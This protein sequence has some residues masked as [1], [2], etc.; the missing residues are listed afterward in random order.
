MPANNFEYALKNKISAT[1][2]K[3]GIPA[4][5]YRVKQSRYVVQHCDIKVDSANPQMYSAI[6][7]KN[8]NKKNNEL[9]FSSHMR[10]PQIV[11]MTEVIRLSGRRGWLA[12]RNRSGIYSIPWPVVVWYFNRNSR[13]LPACEIYKYYSMSP[14]V[15]FS[16]AYHKTYN[17]YAHVKPIL[18]QN[19]KIIIYKIA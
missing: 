7:C 8:L 5:V 4:M 19:S 9:Y 18:T 14:H 16:N 13:C 3:M 12:I 2:L 11:Q 17:Q 10:A 6:E 15:L 1:L